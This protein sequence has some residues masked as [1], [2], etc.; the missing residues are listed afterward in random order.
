MTKPLLAA[1][2]A[3]AALAVGPGAWADDAARQ[4]KPGID[5]RADDVVEGSAATIDDQ[6]FVRKAA[7]GSAA[8]VELAELALAKTKN[9]AVKDFAEQMKRDHTAAQGVLANSA[10]QE[11]IEI[12]RTLD[13]DHST[14]KSEL[15]KLDGQEFDERYMSHMVQEHQKEL[16]LFAAKA[17]TG[18]GDVSA[19]AQRMVSVLD[20]HLTKAREVSAQV[21][22]NEA[23]SETDPR[24][25]RVDGPGN[26]ASLR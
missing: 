24:T 14:I 2:A 20:A 21:A 6:V 4:E 15:A 25:G 11:G 1:A 3:V 7:E 12:P 8:E 13:D 16:A 5:E 23:E 19:Y 9:P 18:D 10:T 26:D 17:R 22:S